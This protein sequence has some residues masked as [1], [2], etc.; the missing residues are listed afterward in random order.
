MPKVL[1]LVTELD[2]G[3]AEKNLFRLACAM[4]KRRWDVEV[5]A[6]SGRGPLGRWLSDE[7][8][9]V[10]YAGM[11]FKADPVAF[12]RL[13]GILRRARPDVL[14]TFL[15]HANIAGRLANIFARVP[16]VVSSIRV[17]ER[18]RPSHTRM[19]FLTQFLMD[20]E[21]C[22]SEGVREFT[23]SQA[24]V[25]ERKLVVIPNAVEPPSPSKPRDDVRAGLG[26][27][28]DVKVVLSVGR[29]D[30]QKGYLYLVEAARELVKSRDDVLFV[31]AGE[32]PERVTMENAIDS[33]AM[34]ERFRLL[35]WRA[36]VD[37]LYSAADIFVLPSLWEGMP[38]ALLEAAAAGLPVVATS[39]EGSREIIDDGRTGLLVEPKDAR[40]LRVALERLLDDCEFRLR[41][42]G[43]GRERVLRGHNPDALVAAH[44]DLYKRLLGSS[45]TS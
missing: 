7:S 1:Y 6:L 5:A 13:V 31:V 2:I 15:F 12:A 22:V 18:R 20:A 28:R 34:G 26:A 9:P 11:D 39:V 17:A 41:L 21:V 27:R 10:H 8:I 25:R 37:D 32:G 23:R 35:G 42:A 29:L 3:G 45:K 24:H 4:K 33:A 36:D 38:N 14:H 43:A 19:D 16:I 30:P 44:E 40:A